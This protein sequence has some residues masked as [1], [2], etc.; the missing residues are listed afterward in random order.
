MLKNID[1]SNIFFT[2]FNFI[3]V[4]NLNYVLNKNLNMLNIKIKYF[5]II[6]SN[7]SKIKVY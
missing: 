6:P 2:Y 4:K 5:N 7:M 3:N 1:E